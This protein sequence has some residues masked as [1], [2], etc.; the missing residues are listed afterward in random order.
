MTD[1]ADAL[2]GREV[3]QPSPSRGT[4]TKLHSF[5]GNPAPPPVTDGWRRVL[6]LSPETRSGFWSVLVSAL[7]EPTDPGSQKRLESF[8]QTHGITEEDAVAAVQACGVLLRQAS[9]LDLDRDH[10]GRDLVSLSGGENVD[11][12]VLLS[13]YDELKVE[14]R[15]RIVGESL[16]S[17]GKVLVGIDW[18]VDNV[19]SSDRGA[20]LNATVILL[21]LRYREGDRVERITLQLTPEAL[22]ELKQFTERIAG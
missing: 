2:G 17:H 6:G 12:G 19:V 22:K 16:I 8:C 9:A 1:L 5:G 18:R 20:R 21:T 7:V 15:Q 14:F 3:D 13:K 11:F 4:E 10:F